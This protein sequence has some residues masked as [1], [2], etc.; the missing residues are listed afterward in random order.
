VKRHTD[1]IIIIIII[2]STN[3]TI[4]IIIT[5]TITNMNSVVDDAGVSGQWRGKVLNTNKY[6]CIQS[7]SRGT[8]PPR[9]P[10]DY[11]PLD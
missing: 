10:T 6:A 2:I 8:R 9:P 7:W 11:S 1:I 4:I 3:T 5:V